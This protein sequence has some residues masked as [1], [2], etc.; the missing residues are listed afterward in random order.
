MN[1]VPQSEQVSVLSI[2]AT[3]LPPFSRQLHFSTKIGVDKLASPPTWPGV[4]SGPARGANHGQN[5]RVAGGDTGKHGPP[6]GPGRA[7]GR[8][9]VAHQWPG[10]GGAR[11][12]RTGA[13]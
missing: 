9:G 7:G 4:F 3:R 13:G 6:R 12:D 10:G 5:R 11:G 8:G 2:T 1:S